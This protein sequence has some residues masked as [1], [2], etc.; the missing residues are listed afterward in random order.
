MSGSKENIHCAIS[1]SFPS[2]RDGVTLGNGGKHSRVISGVSDFQ[3]HDMYTTKSTFFD[4]QS[5]GE[6]S[7]VQFF[8]NLI[9]ATMML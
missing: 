5:V 9:C 3:Q 7:N 8:R 1:S 6:A 4:L 2:S